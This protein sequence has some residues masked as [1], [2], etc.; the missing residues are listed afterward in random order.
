MSSFSS[1]SSASSAASRGLVH[2]H[3]VP[4]MVSSGPAVLA[5]I[6]AFSS[7]TRRGWVDG[8]GLAQRVGDGLDVLDR[9]A[10]VLVQ[11]PGGHVRCR[12][13]GQV[14]DKTCIRT[15]RKLLS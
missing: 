9:R 15:R 8:L 7:W 6:S 1:A 2:R 5:S 13:V 3:Q 11:L 12:E 4:W 14:V 10:V